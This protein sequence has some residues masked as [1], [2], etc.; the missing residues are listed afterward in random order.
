MTPSGR[1]PSLGFVAV[2]LAYLGVGLF[3]CW[4]SSTPALDRVWM[5]KSGL[6]T[7]ELQRLSES[8][9]RLLSREIREHPGLAEA[10]L[11]GGSIGL[12]SANQDGWLATTTATL[13]RTPASQGY[14]VLRLQVETAEELLPFFVELDGREGKRRVDVA[15][16]GRLDIPLAEPGRVPELLELRVNGKKFSADPSVLSLR[17]S[18]PP[19]EEP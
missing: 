7:G 4:A 8:D 12:L 17:V 16:R 9:R 14:R 11:D 6:W 15:R 18:F 3:F 5:L 13:L 2:I 19:P 1:W 10:L